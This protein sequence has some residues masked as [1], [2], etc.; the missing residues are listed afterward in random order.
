MFGDGNCPFRAIAHCVYNRQEDHKIV[1]NL[2]VDHI[3]NNWNEFH[4]LSS[5]LGEDNYASADEYRE[6]MSLHG[7]YGTLR[8][9]VAAGQIFSFVFEVWRDGS[10]YHTTPNLG[11][12]LPSKM[13]DLSGKIFDVLKEKRVWEDT[14]CQDIQKKY[15]MRDKKNQDKK[16][17]EKAKMNKMKNRI[18]IARYRERLKEDRV[19]HAT[20][21]GKE[22]DKLRK[23]K[24][25]KTQK[26]R[27]QKAKD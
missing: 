8:E 19:R 18:R 11:N 1:R 6:K 22:T 15:K 20:A 24:K 5:T 27:T 25:R 23:R 13:L 9:V 12:D 3:C 4:V 17:H 10:L 2:I 16:Q 26:M 7:T 21:K 14:G